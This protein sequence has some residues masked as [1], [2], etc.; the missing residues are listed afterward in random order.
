MA[1]I[2]TDEGLDYILSVIPGGLPMGALSVGVFTSQTPTTVP[3]R[4]H[5]LENGGI[6]EPDAG[7]GGYGRVALTGANWNSPTTVSQGR[8]RTAV[9]K[10]FAESTGAWNPSQANGSFI[11]VGLTVGQG[12]VIFCANFDDNDPALIDAA[13]ITLRVTPFWHL[14][15]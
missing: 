6:E 2:F 12:P 14:D 10:S 1:E 13:G 15:G 8:R 7:V 9:Q 4:S 11:A 3:S 5:T